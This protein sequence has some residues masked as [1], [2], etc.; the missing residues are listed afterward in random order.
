MKK[1]LIV[2]L[3]L[4]L[5]TI[6]NAQEELT[7]GQ[8][9][10]RSLDSSGAQR[11]YQVYTDAG[12]NLVV[13]LDSNA[14]PSEQIE[15]YIKYDAVPSRTEY[16]GKFDE[17]G[18]DQE[19]FINNTQAGHYYILVYAA[20]IG[21]TRSYEICAYSETSAGITI[22]A[23]GCLDGGLDSSKALRVY[24]VYTDA[25]RNLVVTLDSNAYYDEQIELYI[26]YNA[27]PSRTEYDGK[28]DEP[29]PDQEVFINNTQAGYY[30]ILVYAA[31]IG[32]TRS[33]EICALGGCIDTDNDGVCDAIDNCPAIPNGP[34]LGTC[35]NTTTGEIGETC[36]NDGECELGEFCSKNQEDA[37][38]NGIGDACDI[39]KCRCD[40]SGD[41]QCTPQDALCSFQ[42]YLGICPTACGDCADICCDVTGDDQCTPADALCRFQE[43]LGIHPNCFDQE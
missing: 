41:K 35:V 29:G 39:Q 17:P 30:Y 20:S 33:Q 15:L 16:D 25:G 13:T 11:V 18:P 3:F 6:V 31:S 7:V 4:L 1:L 22:P 5:S 8:C 38:A 12:R 10:T 34:L 36:F 21:S 43:Y 14:Y 32:S 23:D 37:D 19:V 28:F 26:R 40:V 2:F 27:I 42:V 9:L 24:Q